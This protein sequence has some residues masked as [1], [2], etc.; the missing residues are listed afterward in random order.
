MSAKKKGN[1]IGSAISM[2]LGLACALV[3]GAVFYGAMAYQL[4][5]EEKTEQTDKVSGG[6]L[7]LSGAALLSEQTKTAEFGGE[8]CSVLVRSYEM[9]DGA[10]VEAITA[11]PEAYIERLSAE[12]YTPQLITGFTLAG[13]DAVY[14]VRGEESLLCARAGGQIFMLRAGAG[15]QS[16]YALGTGAYLE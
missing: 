2:L 3:L 5:D 7:A 16:V 6:R 9:P 8:T 11:Q 1:W 4:L 10:R 15:E 13:M 14:A 12:G